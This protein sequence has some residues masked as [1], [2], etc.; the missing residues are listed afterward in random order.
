MSKTFSPQ[1][2]PPR[3]IDIGQ[4]HQIR[5]FNHVVCLSQRLRYRTN[6]WCAKIFESR[7]QG[8]KP[9]PSDFEGVG[10]SLLH[11]FLGQWVSQTASEKPYILCFVSSAFHSGCTSPG[12]RWIH[13]VFWWPTFIT[14][15]WLV[16][17]E[18]LARAHSNCF[19]VSTFIWLELRTLAESVQITHEALHVAIG[20][21]D[22]SALW[23]RWRSN[24]VWSSGVEIFNLN[25]VCADSQIFGKYPCIIE[26]LIRW[27]PSHSEAHQGCISCGKQPISI[28]V[29]G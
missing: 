12:I 10:L 14:H 6:R 22:T 15:M 7:V 9:S 11:S 8:A 17:F 20:F 4:P 28:P 1:N 5:K 13:L 26:K 2:I 24:A 27:D 18:K 19:R 3:P 23:M 16:W 29:P 25:T 21:F